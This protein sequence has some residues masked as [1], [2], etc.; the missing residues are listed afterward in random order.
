MRTLVPADLFKLPAEAAAEPDEQLDRDMV[1]ALALSQSAA[2]VS[3]HGG[4]RDFLEETARAL[5]TN[6]IELTIDEELED[7]DL[8]FQ[9]TR[10]HPADT[11]SYRVP[12]ERGQE[13]GAQVEPLMAEMTRLLEPDVAVVAVVPAR[14]TETPNYLLLHFWSGDDVLRHVAGVL[15]ARWFEPVKPSPVR[16]IRPAP[17]PPPSPAGPPP[18]DICAV[19]PDAPACTRPRPPVPG[20]CDRWVFGFYLHVW[21]GAWGQTCVTDDPRLCDATVVVRDGDYEQTLPSVACEYVGAS[22][23]PGVYRVRVTRDGF[24]SETLDPVV[25]KPGVCGHS[26]LVNLNVTLQPD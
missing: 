20:E 10:K 25:V 26:E 4:V 23:R 17:M 24:G 18:P 9:L 15:Y 16:L 11:R 21:A 13:L 2:L 8:A 12:E 7:G 5:P 1:Q 22:Q 6:W 3:P 14:A 19:V